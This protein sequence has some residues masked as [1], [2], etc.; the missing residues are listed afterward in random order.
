MSLSE[1]KRV[2]EHRQ[3][4]TILVI[5][6]LILDHYVTGQVSRIS[7]E[8]PVPV[9]DVDTERVAG[10]GAANVAINLAALGFKVML[11]GVV[12]DDPDGVQ[13]K[14]ILHEQNVTTDAVLSVAGRPTTRKTRYIAHSQQVVRVDRET[15]HPISAKTRHALLDHLQ[16]R[17]PD[18]DAVCFQDYN[19][20]LFSTAFIKN[21]LAIT[22]DTIT[23]VDPKFHH[24]FDFRGVTLFKPNLR[25]LKQALLNNETAPP[26]TLAQKALKRLKCQAVLLTRS[27]HGMSLYEQ[28]GTISHI[29]TKARD[30]Y[31]VSGAG[32][33]VIATVT[34]ALACGASLPQAAMWANYAAGV[35]V[36]ELGVVPITYEKLYH[37]LQEN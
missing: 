12:G 14:A 3:Q 26:D 29:P 33:T 36:G 23:T 27:E 25:E 21:A 1:F 24:F 5:G 6:D 15:T 18:L 22:R 8:A 13:L 9:L 2:F 16:N 10:G 4:R 32:D 37:A 7:P 35:V 30:V 28:D 19:K 11:M 17:I 31:D 34:G 20:G